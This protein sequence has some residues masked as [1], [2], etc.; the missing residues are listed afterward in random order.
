[1]EYCKC[2]ADILSPT[3]SHLSPPAISPQATD[4]CHFTPYPDTLGLNSISRNPNYN[5]KHTLHRLC[6]HKHLPSSLHS[7]LGS[8]VATVNSVIETLHIYKWFRTEPQYT[9]RDINKTSS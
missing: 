2:P 3:S 6:D 8:N 1:M 7:V 5:L 4:L 9:L